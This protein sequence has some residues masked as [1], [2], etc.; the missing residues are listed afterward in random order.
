MLTD[1]RV[2]KGPRYRTDSDLVMEYVLGRPVRTFRLPREARARR[3][4]PAVT[5]Y[6]CT[7]LLMT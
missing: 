5:Y 2:C 3:S 1:P 4:L 6:A 7:G